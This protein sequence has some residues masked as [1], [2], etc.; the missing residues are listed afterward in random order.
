MAS[1]KPL[2]KVSRRVSDWPVRDADWL[3]CDGR[4]CHAHGSE[5]VTAMA[6]WTGSCAIKANWEFWRNCWC[7]LRSR[8]SRNAFHF[9]RLA[10]LPVRAGMGH[11]G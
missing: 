1:T 8:H 6:S 9:L 5:V 2:R 10:S 7:Y 11:E 3:P 4:T